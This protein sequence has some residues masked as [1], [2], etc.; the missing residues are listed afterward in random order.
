M[1]ICDYFCKML[2]QSLGLKRY[3]SKCKN[4]DCGS[5]CHILFRMKPSATSQSFRAKVRE[6]RG[7]RPADKAPSLTHF[8]WLRPLLGPVHHKSEHREK[9]AIQY[10][11]ILSRRRQRQRKQFL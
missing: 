4:L 6:F 7:A 1:P 10:V 5:I 3:H 9:E 8:P 11:S 2:E